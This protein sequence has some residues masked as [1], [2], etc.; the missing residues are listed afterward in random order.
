MRC[1]G[2]FSKGHLAV[3]PAK[4]TTCT[5]CKY[6]GLFTRRCKA[7]SKNLNIV[8]SQNVNNTD[9]N[10]S[11]EQPDVNNDRANREC[12]GVIIAWSESGQSN[13]DDYSVL[14]VTT[15]YDNEGKILKKLL[16]LD[17]EKKTK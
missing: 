2:T 7:R 14:N 4:D 16:K 10:Y 11:S 17:K 13:N 6:R 1:G 12:C 15:T 3:C 9:C 8:D 5:S